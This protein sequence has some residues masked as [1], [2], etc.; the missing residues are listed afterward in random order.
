M[1]K[2]FVAGITMLCSLV[3]VPAMSVSASAM[4]TD[5]TSPAVSIDS[6]CVS[7][8]EGIARWSINN[9]SD[10]DVNVSWQGAGANDTYVAT[11]GESELVTPYAASNSAP[12]V[13]TQEG[14]SDLSITPANVACGD[15][16]MRDTSD[17][18]TAPTPEACVDG[19]VRANLDKEWS[20]NNDYVI[21]HTAN[22]APLCDD[23]NLYLTNYTLPSTYD[24]S[25][26]FDDSSIPQ[27]LF[28]SVH[29]VMHKGTNVSDKMTIKVP[30][31]CTD[32]QL[33]LYY[34]PEITEVTG[35]GHGTQLIYGRIYTNTATDCS[36]PVPTPGMGGGDVTPPVETTPPAPVVTPAVTP[37]TVAPAAALYDTGESTTL[38]VIF[39]I[40]AT[41]LALAIK[42]VPFKRSTI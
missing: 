16:S 34:A 13:F 36:A 28:D 5:T 9:G 17:N 6:S 2:L 27:Q 18:E 20:E 22:G 42:F 32:Y 1:P 30:D 25:G 21:V 7:A 38:P 11:Q 12:Y 19:S 10:A 4:P 35:A 31:A 23:I 29:T 33:D 24:D 37:V 41:T 39:A 3:L 8:T 14:Q 15:T 40:F 26:I